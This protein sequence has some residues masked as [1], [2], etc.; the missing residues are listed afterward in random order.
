MVY[1]I[2]PYPVVKLDG[3]I[4][5]IDPKT[6][7]EINKML[8]SEAKEIS[9]AS[10]KKE[11]DNLFSWMVSSAQS[12]LTSA[13]YSMASPQLQKKKAIIDYLKYLG[14]IVDSRTTGNTLELY[15]SWGNS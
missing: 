1:P 4:V 6:N 11:L 2:Q 9:N 3:T 12:G 5:Y 8:A 14:Y 13:I 10:I 15:I 7:K